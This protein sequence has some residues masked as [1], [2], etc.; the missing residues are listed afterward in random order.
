MLRIQN[1]P[2]DARLQPFIAR[3][4]QRE[5][6][7][8]D[9]GLLEPVVARAGTMLEFLFA[10]PYHITVYGSQATRPCPQITVIGPI[11]VRR[12]RLVM[13][14]HMETLV[15]LFRPL[16]LYRFFRTPVRYLAEIGTEGQSALG[17]GM[18][19][20]YE[21]LGNAPSFEERKEVLDSYFLRSLGS[22]PM[23]DQKITALRLL[24]S[25]TSPRSVGEVAQRAGITPRQLERVSLECAG[26]TPR[27]LA[28]VA[29]FERALRLRT[30]HSWS[31]MG[32]AHEAD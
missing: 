19:Q 32:V 2:P 28:R 24:T 21:R 9:A 15:V 14:G 22:Q 23:L 1:T 11:T 5:S 16:G 26:V 25:A 7:P 30:R 31:W 29:R 17:R 10:D 18:S 20:L 27:M 8:D 6:H 12:V 13:R 4:A 3:Y